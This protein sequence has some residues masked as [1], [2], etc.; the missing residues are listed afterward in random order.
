MTPQTT[1]DIRRPLHRQA[2]VSV[3]YT[4]G[5]LLPLFLFGANSVQIQSDLG[6]GTRELGYAVAAFFAAGGL[7]APRI[8]V[9]IDGLSMRSALRIGMCFSLAAALTVS[10]VA[11][12]WWLGAAGM[13]LCGFAHAFTQLTLNRMLVEG[14]RSSDRALGFGMKQAAVP[15]AS[16]VAGLSTAALAPVVAWRS[17]YLMG[18]V[19]I[20]VLAVFV[21]GATGN[22]GHPSP[23]ASRR[24]PGLKKLALAA[25]VAAGAGNSLSLLIVDTF[26]ANGF[27]DTTGAAVLGMGSALA[28]ISRIGGGWVVDRRRSNGIRELRFMLT[29]GAVGF[30]FLALARSSI[31]M[32]LVGALVAFMAAWGWQGVVFFAASRERSVPPATATG[33]VLA[34]TMSGS[35]VGPILIGAAADSLG[36]GRAWMIAAVA[37]IV[38]AVSVRD[39]LSATTDD[40][41]AAQDQPVPIQEEM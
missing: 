28:I 31:A 40:H 27:A 6:F 11:T 16:L 30:V 26:D 4:V 34:G 14:G 15:A 25:A 1:R 2:L 18:A 32:L 29:V 35:V 41:L 12:A 7:T 39:P 38:S 13:A 37:L 8:G 20:L 22:I 21:P 36:Y 5:A 9:L 24:P 10:L 19:A 23:T 17:L 3:V 33:I